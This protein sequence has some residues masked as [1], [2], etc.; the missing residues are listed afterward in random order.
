MTTLDREPGAAG[1]N[2]LI[3]G[4]T[5]AVAQAVAR[6]LVRRGWNLFLAAR[7]VAA[8]EA[9]AADLRVRGGTQVV[10]GRFEAGGVAPSE[11]WTAAVGAFPR[12]L[13]GIL[14][15]HGYLPDER[16][17]LLGSD[18]IR[19]TIEVNFT[20]VAVLLG[21]A[22][23]YFADR[24]R[25]FIAAISSVAGDRGRQSNFCYGAAKAGLTAYLSGLRNRLHPR[26]V[27]VLTIKP[28]II[29]SPMT[30]GIEVGPKPLVATP[31]R[32]A[33]DI[34]RAIL[35]RRDTV[36][37]PWFWRPIMGVI[38]AIPERIFKRMKL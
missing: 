29:D 7:D 15:C 28:G 10:T 30:R 25:G 22:A 12:G 35:R 24:R 33:A 4:A 1:P 20:S 16:A 38:K 37:T 17:G 11:T 8:L 19:R 5:S 13:D 3:V 23:E 2:V 14:V 18:E 36:T 26:N 21:A 31:D 32:V 6:R 9:L 34:E 27:H